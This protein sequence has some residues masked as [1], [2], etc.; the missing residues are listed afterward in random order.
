ML[1]GEYV[2]LN[3][4]ESVVKLLSFVDNCCVI[5]DPSKPNCIVLVCPNLKRIHE[6]IQ[7]ED[8]ENGGGGIGANASSASLNSSSSSTELTN[9]SSSATLVDD[10]RK[11]ADLFKYLDENPSLVGKLTQEMTAM[12]LQQGI[13]RFEIPTRMGFVKE[14]WIPESGLVTDSLKIKRRE[15]EKFYKKEIER[16]YK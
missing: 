7:E 15:V 12:C 3:K 13:D 2:S 9:T 4:V 6:Y 10:I 11:P 5:A 8:K 14:A 16:L 1:G